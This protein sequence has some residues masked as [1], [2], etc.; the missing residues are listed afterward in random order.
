MIL[1]TGCRSTRLSLFDN[2]NDTVLWWTGRTWSFSYT[3]EG[4]GCPDAHITLLMTPSPMTPG[5][6]ERTAEGARGCRVD[7]D[8]LLAFKPGAGGETHH[9]LYEE[10]RQ[11][12][13]NDDWFRSRSGTYGTYPRDSLFRV[14][15][16]SL[17]GRGRPARTQALTS[18]TSVGML[19]EELCTTCSPTTGHYYC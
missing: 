6:V 16:S 9:H 19:T 17:R 1:E 7:E 13:H 14:L 3:T 10:Q 18:V 5:L 15:A 12:T 2:I 11:A 8:L 4:H